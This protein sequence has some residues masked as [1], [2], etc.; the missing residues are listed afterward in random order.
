MVNDDVDKFQPWSGRE[1]NPI[2]LGYAH[3]DANS[4]GVGTASPLAKLDVAGS[5]RARG[6]RYDVYSGAVT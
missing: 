4:V 3:N 1:S 6:E 2:T 5:V